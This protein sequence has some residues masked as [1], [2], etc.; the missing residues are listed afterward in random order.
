MS[1]DCEALTNRHQVRHTERLRYAGIDIG[2]TWVRAA[3]F[4]ERRR[5]LGRFRHHLGRSVA[6]ARVAFE[7]VIG[8]LCSPGAARR[9]DYGLCLPGII[10]VGKRRLVRCVN[11]PFLEGVDFDGW[12]RDAVAGCGSS[13][14]AEH[15]LAEVLVDSEAACRGAMS[16]LETESASI[17][18]LRFGTGVGLAWYRAGSF[19]SL[20]RSSGCHVDLLRVPG[21]AVACSCG[22]VGCIEAHIHQA[23][24]ELVLGQAIGSVLSAIC[25]HCRPGVLILGGG[26]FVHDMAFRRVLCRAASA[27]QIPYIED[28]LG[29]WAGACGAAFVAADG[30]GGRS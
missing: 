7:S 16:S 3:A 25:S 11:A 1:G 20:S 9:V 13:V 2:G 18:H 29:D 8:A 5:Q 14:V 17:V 21:S 23:D 12:L 22:L 24:T 28:E 27:L 26:R 19:A 6:D 10:D 15:V 4:D 30:S